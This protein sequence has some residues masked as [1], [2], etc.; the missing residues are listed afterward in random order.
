MS[1]Y[2]KREWQE[3][4]AARNA[5]WEQQREREAKARERSARNARRKLERLHRTLKESGEITDF[6]DEFAESVTERLDQFGS[7]FHDLEKGRPGDALSTA[8]KQVVARMNRKVKEAK[9]AARAAKLGEDAP[10]KEERPRSS[11]KPKRSSFKP[12]SGYTP[13][14]RQ[15]DEEFEAEPTTTER[16]L[17]AVREPEHSP[18]PERPPVGK[19]FLRVVK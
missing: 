11:F 3:R 18:E 16:A 13:R 9:K 14:V 15:L 7:A 5:A 10:E 4:E 19:P 6:E 1:D 12:K 8:Q 17:E 2:D